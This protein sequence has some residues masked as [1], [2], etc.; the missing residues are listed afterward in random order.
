[1]NQKFEP[2]KLK[3]LRPFIIDK[4]KSN[5]EWIELQLSD[6]RQWFLDTS[7]PSIG[8]I[9]AAMNIWFL[10]ITKTT[11]EFENISGLYPKTHQWFNR[12]IK[13]TRDSQ[14]NKPPR[15]SGEE[16]L[17]IAKN[18]KSSSY[19]YNDSNK[20]LGNKKIGDKVTISPD[21]YGKVP[22][23]GTVL[24]IGDRNI[25]IRPIDVDKTGIDVVI[26]FPTAGYNIKLD[27]D[28]DINSNIEKSKL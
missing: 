22:V 23:K 9:H 10:N 25:A 16:A 1:M 3:P 18:F 7:T 15:I 21:D 24:S 13:F 8:D 2:N 26:W 4:L 20:R 12:F 27:S 17:E 11:K 6:D 14:Q 19:Y 5:Y 28:N